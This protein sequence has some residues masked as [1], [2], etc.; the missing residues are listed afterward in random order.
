MT[1]QARRYGDSSRP[2]APP[3][4]ERAQQP[5]PVAEIP[6]STEPVKLTRPLILFAV[7]L[8]VVA[9]VTVAIA[10]GLHLPNADWMPIAGLVAMKPS[11]G[12]STLAAVQ[13]L[14]GAIIGGRRVLADR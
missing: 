3:G 13:R 14:A 11:L 9:A 7:I 2:Y 1:P 4:Q 6:G 8:A 5:A 12:Q 10:F